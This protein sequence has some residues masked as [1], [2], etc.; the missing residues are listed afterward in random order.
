MPEQ[1]NQEYRKTIEV[2]QQE[3]SQLAEKIKGLE[4]FQL[5]MRQLEALVGQ[6]K[7]VVGE[8]IEPQEP[9]PS[10][11][12]VS[13]SLS[14]PDNSEKPIYLKMV[15]IIKEAGEPLSLVDMVE[16]FRKREWKLSKKNPRE[17]LRNTLKAKPHIFVKV[18]ERGKWS[19]SVWAERTIIR[20]IK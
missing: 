3:I 2:A 16:E 20:A 17:V 18:G 11:K 15:Q 7:I 5:R 19:S 1:S 8:S 13:L 12:A 9:T 4:K 10:D 14:Y 6:A